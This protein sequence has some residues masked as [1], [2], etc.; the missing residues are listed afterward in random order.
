[1]FSYPSRITHFPGVR[2]QQP[3]HPVQGRMVPASDTTVHPGYS[4]LMGSHASGVRS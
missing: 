3:K 1:M 4:R 2:F